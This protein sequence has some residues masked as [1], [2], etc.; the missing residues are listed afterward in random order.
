MT[1]IT[2]QNPTKRTTEQ[3]NK[4]TIP[5]FTTTKRQHDVL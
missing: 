1:F 5:N 2:A 4:K 3:F